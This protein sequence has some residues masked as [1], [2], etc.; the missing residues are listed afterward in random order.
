M[1]KVKDDV[2]L[3]SEEC[4]EVKCNDCEWTGLNS[5][6]DD[7]EVDF[8]DIGE[9]IETFKG[10]PKC[11]VDDYLMDMEKSCGRCGVITLTENLNG[12]EGLCDKC[13]S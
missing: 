13:A 11:R 6:L 7:C 10:C 4:D 12:N 5:D 2:L 3:W 9:G 1:S 8:T